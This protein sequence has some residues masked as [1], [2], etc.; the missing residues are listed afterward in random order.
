MV[1]PSGVMLQVVSRL[2]ELMFPASKAGFDQVSPSLVIWYRLP[3]SVAP[4]MK[5]IILW[6]SGDMPAV[7]TLYSEAIGIVTGSDQ[8]PDLLYETNTSSINLSADR[9][10][11]VLGRRAVNAITLSSA[12]TVGLYSVN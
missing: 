12:D 2:F 6:P 3:G 7:P 4:P 1:L 9:V 10:R 11:P 8:V 5:I